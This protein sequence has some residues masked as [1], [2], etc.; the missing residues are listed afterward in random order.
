[1]LNKSRKN[2]KS[3][4]YPLIKA[5]SHNKIKV[6]DIH[7]IYYA[8]YGNPRGIPLCVI[9]GGPGDRTL[10]KDVRYMN[11]KKYKII[12]VDQRGCGKSTPYGEIKDNK[13]EDLISDFEKIR[14]ELNIKKWVLFGGSWG[15]T[16]ALAYSY[17]HPECVSH[18]VIRGVYLATKDEEE[19][20]DKNGGVNYIYPDYWDN[21]VENIPEKCQKTKRCV[22]N[23][24]K[25]LIKNKRTRKN[26]L[27]KWELWEG[28][29]NKL[30]TKPFNKIKKYTLNNK[31]IKSAMICH[32]YLSN[33]CYFPRDNYLLEKRNVDK[34]K[35]IPVYIIQ[36]RYDVI[37]PPMFA[38]KLHK[39]LP[40][41][42]LIFTLGG[43]STNDIENTKAL[44]NVMNKL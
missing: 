34:I 30:D 26:A 33:Y 44:V 25:K 40:K 38:Y 5:N 39:K 36:G 20:F 41:S 29:L 7:T 31:Q 27:S 16:L 37:C 1:M 18:I 14:N 35:D 10:P 17:K 22:T 2:N 3:Y 15:S 19:W 32:K 42:K 12:L 28:G 13:T 8:V 4:L 11:P 6:S 43:H 23:K 21:F 9:H 24:Y